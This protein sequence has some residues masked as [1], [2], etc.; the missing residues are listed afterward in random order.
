[1][2]TVNTSGVVGSTY[3]QGT[4]DEVTVDNGDAVSGYPTVG[5][6]DNAILPGTAAVKVPS[7]DT[8]QRPAGSQGEFRF[9]T[10][11]QK[12]EGFS[13]AAWRQ[14]VTNTGGVVSVA[15]GGTGFSSYSV[16]DMVYASSPTAFS[17][18]A[19]GTQG[20]VIIAGPTGPAW[21]GIS[22]GTF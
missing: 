14:V 8:S 3:I 19:L 22:G 12:F 16:G 21:S 20:Y 10:E 1:L 18:L 2:V 11:T 17:K 6:A 13:N 4:S 15:E 9:N 5:L 7:G